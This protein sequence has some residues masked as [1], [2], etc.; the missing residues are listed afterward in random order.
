MISTIKKISLVVVFL[1][2]VLHPL[3]SSTDEDCLACHEDPGLQTEEGQSL[4]IE[5][6][7]HLS[8]VHGEAGLSCVDCH[9]DLQ[10]VEDF[11]HAEEL[12][13]VQCSECHAKAAQEFKTS[14]HSQATPEKECCYVNCRDCH[15]SHDIRRKKDSQSRIYPLNLP[16]TCER[17][18]LEKVKTERGGEFIKKYEKSIHYEGLEKAGLATSSNCSTCHGFHDIRKVH[19]PSSRVSKKNIIHTCGD[20]H[21]GIERDYLE[22]VHGKDYLKGSLDVP[23]CTDCHNEHD[24]SSP[25]NL[26]SSVYS[27]KVSGVCSRCHDDET[28]S[29]EYG[30]LTQRLKTYSRSFHGTA[31]QFGE[32]RVANCAS[33]HGFHAIRPSS[34]PKSSIHPD[35][36]AKTCG[37]CHAGAGV[38]FTKGKIHVVSEKSTNK[39]A[40]YVKIFYTIIIGGIVGIFLIFI[41]ADLFH[42]LI[43]RGELQ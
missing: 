20:C 35:N 19:D 22:G 10:G 1:L 25:Q 11:P 43:N 15:G 41:A 38:N 32:A 18:H 13:E 42:R 7:V 14:I 23:V 34:D 36:L 37:K 40:Y 27:T 5:S 30:F 26:S 4:F 33:C 17:C 12:S 2:L 31:S 39:A 6:R 24:I 29:R 3:F 9:A 16:R 21:I 28:L 8:S